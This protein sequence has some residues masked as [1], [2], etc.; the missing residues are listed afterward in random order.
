MY[1]AYQPAIGREVAVKV[2]RAEVAN[3]PAFVRRFEA[4]TRSIAELDSPQVVPIFDFWREPDG[5][6]LV[7]K[8]ITG[9][10]LHSLLALGPTP[11]DRVCEIVS[12]L[13]LPLARAH[14]LGIVHGAVTL[15]NVL[16][17]NDGRPLITDFGM[18]AG[19][20][21]S[22]DI[23]GLAAC[24][25]QLIVGNDGSLTELVNRLDTG[26]AAVLA[27]PQTFGTIEEFAEAFRSAVGATQGPVTVGDIS[28]PYQG[29][30]S[31]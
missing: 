17:D 24:A 9:G 10:S 21:P 28:N 20:T 6:I 26:I 16:L 12:Q 31:V 22:D 3:D 23:E 25:A 29:L 15:D 5:A 11:V 13:V 27:E 14:E 7:E 1:R 18:G 8:L 2:I 19:S 4:E 30:G